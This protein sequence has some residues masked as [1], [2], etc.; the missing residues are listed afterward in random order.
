MISMV[1]PSKMAIPQIRV[2][3]VMTFLEAVRFENPTCFRMSSGGSKNANVQ[4]LTPPTNSKTSP[5]SLTT[6]KISNGIARKYKRK[7][8]HTLPQTKI[9]LRNARGGER[10]EN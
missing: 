4:A 8:K 1:L 3:M 6:K 5:K 7:L 2:V 9:R 10:N